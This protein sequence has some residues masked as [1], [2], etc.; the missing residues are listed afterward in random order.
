ML[1]LLATKSCPISISSA[2][3][4]RRVVCA[5][6]AR[7]VGELANM[8]PRQIVWPGYPRSPSEAL[9]VHDRRHQFQPAAVAGPGQP[10]DDLGWAPCEDDDRRGHARRARMPRIAR[11]VQAFLV[12]AVGA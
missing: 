11:A 2:V 8:R 9:A 3:I 5:T 10:I 1:G 12:L 6:S 7:S 4:E